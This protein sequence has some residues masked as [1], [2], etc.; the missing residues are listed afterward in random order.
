MRGSR[1]VVAGLWWCFACSN[2]S[3]SR[4]PGVP[5]NPQPPAVKHSTATVTMTAV[6][7]ADDCGGVPPVRPPS[8]AASEAASDT[9]KEAKSK[10]KADQGCEQSSM[11]LSL[12]GASE[13]AAI[14]VRV[15]SAELFDES[16]SKVGE[17]AVSLPTAWSEPAG[18]YQPWDQ[19]IA[20]N[21]TLAVSYILSRPD[22]KSV[23]QRANK[24]Y[25]LKAVVGVGA[26]DQTVEHAVATPTILPPNVKT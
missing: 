2:P 7:L 5:P 9:A 8:H 16:G 14:P 15:T 19:T 21:Q 13:G 6:T 4:E 23:A 25:V 3:T 18:A 17:L 26:G 22:W 20:P 11:Q 12:T 10:R 24:A 1:S